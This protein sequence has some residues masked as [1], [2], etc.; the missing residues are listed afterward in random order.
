MLS[1][2]IYNL[3]ISGLIFGTFSAITAVIL[4]PSQYLKIQKQEYH[5]EN[6]GQIIK[7]T[8]QHNNWKTFFVGLKPYAMLS[9]LTST[10]FG[11]ADYISHKIVF[12]LHASIFLTIIIRAFF[13]GIVESIGVLYFEI[14][15]IIRNK[16]KNNT[17]CSN[18]E[19][20]IA[21]VLGMLIL[22]N[23]D[24]RVASIIVSEMSLIYHFT[25]LKS[26]IYSF[27]LGIVFGIITNPFDVL[28]TKNCGDKKD[29]KIMKQLFNIVTNANN[30]ERYA[31]AIIRFFQIGVYSITT[32][33]TLI[34]IKK[35]D[36]VL[37]INH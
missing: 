32:I 10:F 17:N 22:R 5:N 31:G 9:F 15:E 27:V 19:T 12:A 35:F 13:G 28:V 21:P 18:A 6:Y 20:K 25:D 7:R 34:F 26:M 37:F 33:L 11:I 14:Q 8:L 4:S 36:S 29:I 16:N 2:E 3:I 23:S 1:T 24:V 30:D